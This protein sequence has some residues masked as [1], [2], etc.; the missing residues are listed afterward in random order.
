MSG[1]ATRSDVHRVET[2]LNQLWWLVLAIGITTTEALSNVKVPSGFPL[3]VK[4]CWTIFM[5][6][7]AIGVQ[8]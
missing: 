6:C 1:R 7:K 5:W 3:L 4:V 8:F 2:A